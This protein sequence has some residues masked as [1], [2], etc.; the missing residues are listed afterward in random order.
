MDSIKTTAADRVETISKDQFIN[1]Y[2][3][4]QKP[5]VIGN[6]TKNWPAYKTWSLDYIKSLAGNLTVPLYDSVPTKGRQ[7]SAEP[8]K[9]MKLKDYIEL[10]KKEPTDLRM[11]FFNILNHI[12]ELTKDFKY[13]DIGLKFFK[14]LPVL[15]FGGEG[16]KVL[17]HYDIDLANNMLF[18]FHGKKTVWLFPPEQTKYLYRVPYTIHNIEKINI[19]QPDF[20]SY[21]A[22]KKAQG[23]K[24]V[25]HHGD[26]LFIPSGYWH[27]VSYDTA[28]FSMSLRAFP[29]SPKK[30]GTLL[31]NVF[32]MRHF[33]NAMRKIR[34]Q[35][36]L[37]YKENLVKKKTQE[38]LDN[39]T[40]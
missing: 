24:A 23:I 35:K 34:G 10:L 19:E 25:L 3:K 30:L 9:K 5:V 33:E 2:F 36:W 13:P 20:K 38:K 1:N 32:I 28:G 37:D 40:L 14:K 31:Y 4:T 6:L 7:S 29:R 17:M 27:Y 39:G 8:V 26:A 11:F 22:L 16:S 12:P 15:F 18:H 21:P